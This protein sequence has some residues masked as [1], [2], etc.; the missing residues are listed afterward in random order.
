MVD[1]LQL[2]RISNSLFTARFLTHST[3]HVRLANAFVWSYGVWTAGSF[4]AVAIRAPL[5][6]PWRSR[7]GT[8]ILVRPNFVQAFCCFLI[9]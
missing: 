1:D 8:E 4:F 3:P 5:Q 9:I 2:T 6:T 7:D